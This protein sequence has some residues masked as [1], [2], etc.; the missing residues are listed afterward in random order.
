MRAILERQTA[1]NKRHRLLVFCRWSFSPS[2]SRYP[3]IHTFYFSSF[4]HTPPSPCARPECN[5]TKTTRCK[6]WKRETIKKRRWIFSP[7]TPHRRSRSRKWTVDIAER[8]WWWPDLDFFSSFP[9]TSPRPRLSSFLSS[10]YTSPR[11]VVS[12]KLELGR[13]ADVYIGPGRFSLPTSF[14]FLSSSSRVVSTSYNI[15]S[16]HMPSTR[17]PP[18]RLSIASLHVLFHLNYHPSLILCHLMPCC[19]DQR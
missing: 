10:L 5:T 14:T 11:V 2:L 18:S 6:G 16:F 3:Y 7:H 4:S 12:C 17:C 1:R 9:P 8:S 19:N 15:L 13:N